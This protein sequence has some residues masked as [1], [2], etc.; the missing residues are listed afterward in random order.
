MFSEERIE[1]A[2]PSHK[3]SSVDI[4]TAQARAA[5][6]ATLVNPFANMTTED[7]VNAGKRFAEDKGLG[8]LT[9]QF[10]V[11][12]LLA[13]IAISE[14]PRGFQEL[15]IPEKDKMILHDELD[16]RWKQKKE[17]YFL[18]VMCSVAAA[19][20]GVSS[21]QLFQYA[22]SYDLYQMDETVT[23]GAQLYY[24]EQFGIQQNQ[25]LIGFVNSAPYVSEDSRARPS[26]LK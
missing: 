3:E 7:L 12:A 10:K 13:R 14:D 18:V 11:A 21:L 17:L 16:H 20:Q 24:P 1:I 22:L 5:A 15:D 6:E 2:N 19:V 23:N 8:H 26:H 9:E 25:F 4:P